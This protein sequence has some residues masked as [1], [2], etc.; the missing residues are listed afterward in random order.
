MAHSR[1]NRLVM[2]R[3]CRATGSKL[4]K[5]SED[6]GDGRRVGKRVNG[7]LVQSFTYQDGL[8][9]IAELDASGSVVSRFVYAT[10]KTAPKY[11]IKG[12]STYRIITD[13]VGSSRLVI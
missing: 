6:D 9:P 2:A 12:S 7:A 3:P 11:V 4:S 10:S 1:L 13:P 8:R 5:A